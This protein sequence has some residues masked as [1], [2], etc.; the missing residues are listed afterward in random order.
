MK[1]VII[2]CHRSDSKLENKMLNT[3]LQELKVLGHET[4]VVNIIGD[5]FPEGLMTSQELELPTD[6]EVS[7]QVRIVQ[8]E[9]AECNNIVFLFP[10]Y[11]NEM[12]AYVRRFV[13]KVFMAEWGGG[14]V[15]ASDKKLRNVK[16]SLITSMRIPQI[17]FSSR[18]AGGYSDSFTV[19][20]LKLCGIRN[21]KWFNIG[22]WS[23]LNPKAKEK[24]IEKIRDYF[25]K[26]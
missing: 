10:H 16:A 5:I 17:L 2:Y 15:F 1:T 8:E 6:E 12:A 23:D 11:W 20:I 22:L 7:E 26:L 3:V 4:Y 14:R 19:S 24:K 9:I 25:Q 18:T 13:D 21:I